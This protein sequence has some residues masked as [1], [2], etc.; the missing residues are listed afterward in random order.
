MPPMALAEAQVVIILFFF[1]KIQVHR[2]K[3]LLNQDF[4]NRDISHDGD[5]GF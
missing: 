2:Q 5:I 3:I 4:F 1:D